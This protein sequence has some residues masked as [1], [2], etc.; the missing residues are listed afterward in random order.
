MVLCAQ[1]NN[2]VT[3]NNQSLDLAGQWSGGQIAL[4]G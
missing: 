3:C 2:L 1:L 4:L